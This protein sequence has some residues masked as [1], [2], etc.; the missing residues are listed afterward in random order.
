MDQETGQ[1]YIANETLELFATCVTSINSGIQII[2]IL[3]IIF[4][5]VSLP[6]ANDSS[7]V[8]LGV[9]VGVLLILLIVSIIING[10]LMIRYISNVQLQLIILL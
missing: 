5:I 6:F 4:L 7:V 3:L 8:A 1:L 2:I 9:L 10:W